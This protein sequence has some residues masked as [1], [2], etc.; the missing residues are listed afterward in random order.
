M[1]L[2]GTAVARWGCSLKTETLAELEV[3]Q[4]DNEVYRSEISSRSKDCFV[5]SSFSFRGFL[6]ISVFLILLVDICRILGASLASLQ[7]PEFCIPKN[8]TDALAGASGAL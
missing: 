2:Y 8:G 3:G 1:S 4:L 5:L 7:I 6:W